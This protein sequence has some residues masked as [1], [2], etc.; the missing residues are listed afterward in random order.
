MDNLWS[1]SQNWTNGSP[2][3][4]LSGDV[5][6]V[7]HTNLSNPAQLVTQ[8]DL[9]G[10]T[11]DSIT[12]DANVGMIGPTTFATGGTSTA[13]YTI[14]GNTITI[15]VS[16]AGQDPFGID[17]AVGIAGGGG[18]TQ[19]FNAG[20]AL[21][22]ANA[23]FRSQEAFARLTLNGAIDLG[24]R[25]LTIDN[26]FN[27]ATPTV[28]MSGNISNGN[29]IK[30]G[31][32]EL[33][34]TGNNSYSDTT[35]NSGRVFA[36]TNTALGA[37][38]GTLTV[39]DPGQVKLRNGVT[40][41]KT[42]L[43][44]NSNVSGGG[45]G[46]DG[47]TTNTFRGNVVLLAGNSG[48]ALGAG[49][50]AA[51]AGARLVVDGVIS[52]ATST[53]FINGTGTVQFTKNNTYTGVTQINGNQ[54]FTTLQIDAPTGLGAGGDANRTI[55][56]NG[57]GGEPGGT[58]ALNFNGTLQDLATVPEEIDFAGSGVGALGAVRSLGNSNVILPGN[59]TFIAAAPWV[60]AVDGPAGSMT[61]TGIIDSQGANRALTKIGA[62]T[63][64]IGGTQ[65]NVFQ[66][67][68]IINGGTLSVQNTSASPLGLLLGPSGGSVTVNSTGTLRVETGVT[69]PNPVNV[70]AGGT[71]AGS[72]TVDNTVTST[73]GTI[74]PGASTAILTVDDN[75][76]LDAASTFR[77]EINGLTPGS[78]HDQ[79]NVIGSV[80]L[81]N[82]TLKATVNN[83]AVL[84]LPIVLI[85]NDGVDPVIGQFAGLAE[86]ATLT[87][88]G[89]AFRI[90]YVGDTGNDVTLTLIQT[91]R[92]AATPPPL[93]PSPGYFVAGAPQENYIR[94]LFLTML[95]REASATEVSNWIWFWGQVGN[96]VAV[97][98]GIFQS[99]EHRLNQAAYYYRSF[100]GRPGS[101]SEVLGWAQLMVNGLSEEE[102][103]VG[104]L[105]SPEFS[106]GKDNTA[107]VTS[108]YQ[109]LLFRAPDAG[110]LAY[111]VQDLANGQT[112]E[113]VVRSFLRSPEYVTSLVN[114]LYTAY[115]G[116][117]PQPGEAAYWIQDLTSGNLSD[118]N[119]ALNL[120]IS[121]EF[122]NKPRP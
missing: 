113:Q 24:T 75:V 103:I 45:L 18:L 19:T 5:D 74:S 27:N 90:S 13:G 80:N 60:F 111:W 109:T 70:N 44:L 121:F 86:G 71:L 33:Q 6:L 35:V 114:D 97:A 115:L 50:G 51:N 30:D 98:E 14:N 81:G 76:T 66:N 95:G 39:N 1:N 31:T 53:L 68:V 117:T 63:L 36:D 40:V 62:G 99:L 10:L 106:S 107:F 84:N 56:N 25:T 17:L 3:S 105:A 34:L 21:L 67:G 89:L 9:V 94:D 12:F 57:G 16:G 29:L 2:G 118:S 48:V 37:T 55:I 32:G 23:T 79:L 20:L 22:N 46:V 47:N 49:N 108:L 87:V 119:F 92:S 96:H 91:W 116:R 4:D 38:T 83:L 110:S 59:I 93:L 122:L 43:N 61:L 82:A 64:I 41:E 112:R 77:A 26:V 104:F 7:F 65:A 15:D 42:T 101:A 54:G 72:G 11:V 85:A 88:N 8:N 28:A 78:E 102:V 69:I 100:L 73:G 52:G 120:L 58:L